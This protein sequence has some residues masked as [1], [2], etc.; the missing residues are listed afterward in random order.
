MN[1]IKYL[2]LPFLFLLIENS[3]S[4]EYKYKNFIEN[5]ELIPLH[6]AVSAESVD[7]IEFSSFSCSHCASFHNETL[8]EL[9]ESEFFENIN[10]YVVDF[11]LNQAAFYASVIAS[12]DQSIRPSY[13]DLVYANYDIWTEAAS[14]EKMIELLNS[15]GLQLGLEDEQLQS[16]LTNE[17][18]QNEILS[19]QVASQETFGIESTPTFLINGEK[20]QG[21]RPST[22]F[23]KIIKKELNK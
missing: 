16:C 23:I 2:I 6:Q 21:N 3:I 11:P 19:L 7:I 15:Y 13:V 4:K 8:I 5:N 20:I 1:K 18:L 17:V 9:K 10:Y 22:E 14:G 12:C